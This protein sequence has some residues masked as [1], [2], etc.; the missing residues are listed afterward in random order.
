MPFVLR[1]WIVFL[2]IMVFGVVASLVSQAPE[3]DQP[4]ALSDINFSTRPV[5]NIAALIVTAILVALY[6]AYW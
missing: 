3:P 1:I 4:V 6:V 2:T 5:F